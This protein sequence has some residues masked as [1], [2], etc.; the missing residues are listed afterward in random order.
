MHTINLNIPLVITDGSTSQTET[1]GKILAE[2][3]A[4]ETEGKTLKLYGWYKELQAGREL[5]L[6]DVDLADLRNLVDTNKRLYLYVKGQILE[7]LKR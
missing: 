7:A 1:L 4:T 3:L 2:I 5:I 6:D